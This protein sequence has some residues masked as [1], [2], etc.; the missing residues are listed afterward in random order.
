MLRLRPIFLVTLALASTLACVFAGGVAASPQKCVIQLR[1][2]V[3]GTSPGSNW[4]LQGAL[5]AGQQ[6]TLRAVARGC[7]IAQIRGR[8]I[9]GASSA[10]PARQCGGS[11]T[12]VLHVRSG[13]Q[14][15]AA[16]QAFATGASARSN[17]VRV[18]WAGSCTAVGTWDQ[19]TDNIGRTTWAIKAGGA[20]QESGIGNATGTATFSSHVL[21]ITFVADDQVTT[22]VYAWTLSPNCSTGSGTLTFTGPASRVGESHPSIVKRTGGG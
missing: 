7:G 17:V 5:N 14:S 9:S 4:A 6:A 21:R 8:W 19:K 22:G 15:A 20:A 13:R 12:C 1:V 16:F 10:I 18:A 2:N 3:F 11:S